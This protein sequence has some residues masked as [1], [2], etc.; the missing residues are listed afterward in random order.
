MNDI[1]SSN[2]CAFVR[3]SPEGQNTSSSMLQRGADSSTNAEEL[4]GKITLTT[5]N[6]A[7]FFVLAA[8]AAGHIKNAVFFFLNGILK[9]VWALSIY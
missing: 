5:R 2:S 1:L 6:P 9:G 8:V 3:R 7:M 4:L